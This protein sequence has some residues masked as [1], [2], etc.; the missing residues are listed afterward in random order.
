MSNIASSPILSSMIYNATE[1]L[2]FPLDNKAIKQ[3]SNNNT[4]D[5]DSSRLLL[6]RSPEI[7]MNT[8]FDSDVIE[9]LLRYIYTGRV[10]LDKMANQ[11]LVAAN[12]YELPDL[13]KICEK[14]LIS[15]IRPETAIEMYIVGHQSNSS[16]LTKKAFSIMKT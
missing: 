4:T 15:T 14:Y 13:K 8:S 6:K 12:T 11:L 1:G 9:Q 5:E 10:S 3:V 2:E 7:E 16:K